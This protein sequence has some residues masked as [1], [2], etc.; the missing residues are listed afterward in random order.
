M[1]RY[2]RLVVPGIPHHVT[3]RGVQKRKTFFRSLDY[4]TYL[5]L[6]R[7]YKE[8]AGVVI[9]AYCLMPNHIHMVVVPESETSL[10]K[11][12]GPLHAQYAAKVN[13]SHGWQGHLWQQRFYSVAMDEK[14][15]LAAIRYVELNP[16]RAGLCKFPYEWR[17]S[18]A[19]AHLTDAHDVLL[20]KSATDDLVSDWREYLLTPGSAE[21]QDA[22][23]RHTRTG[24]PV[25]DEDFTEQ[26]EA[27][28][29]RSIQVRKPG[30]Q[31]NS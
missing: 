4:L 19:N 10:A 24:R 14:H 8:K 20:D 23:R 25:G 5:E 16:V 13:V 28:T 27:L 31:Q 15:T 22:L 17:W 2:P 1:P 6:L 7:E 11:C 26:L 18:S 3:Q 29:G 30:P 21:A 9:C 12:F